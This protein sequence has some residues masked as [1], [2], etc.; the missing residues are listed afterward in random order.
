VNTSRYPIRLDTLHALLLA[1]EAERPAQG[2]ADRAHLDLGGA[3]I[4]PGRRRVLER[5]V[6]A[7][8][9]R[10]ATRRR[11]GSEYGVDGACD[12]C[13]ELVFTEKFIPPP[14]STR[15]SSSRPATC[16]RSPSAYQIR[17]HVRSPFLDPQRNR[18][19]AARRTAREGRHEYPIA[20]L[21]LTDRELTG[22]GTQVPFYEFSVEVVMRDGQVHQSAGRRRARSTTCSAP[23][24][25]ARMLGYLPGEEKPAS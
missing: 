17:V 4:P 5:A 23:R 20:R 22:A 9:A 19:R 1:P 7:V 21:F 25:C 24:R 15:R 11:S 16:S 18:D 12:A 3:R 2:S 13:D 10:V 8:V 6:G 14:P